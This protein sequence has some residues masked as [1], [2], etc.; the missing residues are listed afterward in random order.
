VDALELKRKLVHL[1]EH[2]IEHNESH[3]AEYEK[4]AQQ[5]QAAGLTK[6]AECIKAAALVIKEAKHKL[7]EALDALG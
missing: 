7:Q 3:V 4:W 2:W 5:A 1:I 6:G